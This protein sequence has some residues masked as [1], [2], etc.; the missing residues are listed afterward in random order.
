MCGR[1]ALTTTREAIV[2]EF[3]IGVP[4]DLDHA[5]RYNIAP[6]QP[7]L[8]VRP[9][10]NGRELT[11]VRWGLV[12]HWEKYLAKARK[13]INARSETAA[14]SGMFKAALKYRRCLLPATG[15]YEWRAIEGRKTKQPYLIRQAD[16]SI[17]ALAGLWEHW[18][19]AEGNELETC[20]ILTTTPNAEMSDLHNRMPVIIPSEDRDRW[21][22]A[23]IEDPSAVADLLQPL[24]D[25]MLA[26]LPVSTHVN[27]VRHDDPRCVET[28]EDSG[29]LW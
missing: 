20:T 25:G 6:S 16:E 15:F 23:G 5:P 27:N 28:I 24:P 19:D 17:M 3:N 14:T 4:T 18:Q 21:L 12:P 8:V 1:Y 11:P 2:D 29:S 26:P 7:V 9:T 10:P 22:D 13:P